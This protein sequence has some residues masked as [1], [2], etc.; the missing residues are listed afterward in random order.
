M[1]T[2][3]PNQADLVLLLEFWWDGHF[4]SVLSSFRVVI[5][6]VAPAAV[7]RTNWRR[8]TDAPCLILE[9]FRRRRRNRMGRGMKKKRPVHHRGPPHISPPSSVTDPPHDNYVGA[10][11]L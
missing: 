1:R 5:A 3:R 8:F 10:Q 11:A 9:M 4:P 7:G 6:G 2:M